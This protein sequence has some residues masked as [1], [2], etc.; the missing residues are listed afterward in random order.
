[1]DPNLTHDS[2][3]PSERTTQTASLSFQPSLHRRPYSVPILYNGTPILSQKF[4]PSHGGSG[5]PSNTWFPGPTQVLNP[6]GSS[7]SAAVCAGLTSVTDRPRY[8]VGK[9]RPHL[10]A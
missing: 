6:N 3:G 8:T 4:A 9:N 2:Y 10:R 5:P 7:I 1:M